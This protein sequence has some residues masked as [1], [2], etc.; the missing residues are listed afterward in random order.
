[1]AGDDA[2]ASDFATAYDDGA[3]EA[4]G[5][6]GDLVDAFA[7]LGR[8]TEAALAQHRRADARSVVNGAVVY[9]GGWLPDT[10]YVAVLP[11]S[12]PSSLGGNAFELPGKVEW[13]LDHVGGFVW[14]DADVDRVRSA[15]AAWS[16]AADGLEDLV[17]CCDSATRGFWHERS[18]EIPIALDATADLRTTTTDVATR[19][20]TLAAHCT[21]YAD[22]VEEHRRQVLDLAEWLLE[23]VV[24]GILISVGIGL[25]TGG[26]GAGAA[27]SAVVARVVA[28]S[29]RFEEILL[30]LRSLTSALASTTR[31]TRDLL[32]AS[33]A[34]LVK[35][36]E[37][38]VTRGLLRDERGSI[39]LG[40]W[41]SKWLRAHEHSGSH[42]IARHTGLT[43]AQLRHRLET[44]THS[45]VSTFRNE[46]QA[47]KA[48]RE[49][50]T[51]HP[52]RIRAWIEGDSGRLRLDASL[53]SST[54]ISMTRNGVVDVRGVRI[55]L[56]RDPS[57]PDGYR[58]L[59]AFPQA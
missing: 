15:A 25:I 7:G 9:D 43:R 55:I 59:T 14:P 11:A 42:T 18:P 5:A 13:I 39:D 44:T 4:L 51:A 37:A 16:A 21:A 29:R 35:F 32:R 26:A 38:T 50:L 31:G 57:M 17:T 58:I 30:A 27:G 33:R 20:A 46:R 36:R 48:I 49:G 19:L 45:Q 3:R 56:V 2:T 47:E 34:R 22:D 28:E 23:Q 1:M 6:L 40:A 8:L 12:P 53:R 41:Q 10:G 54:G 24:E 52:E